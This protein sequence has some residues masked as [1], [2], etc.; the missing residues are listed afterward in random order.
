MKKQKVG[1]KKE[2]RKE[3]KSQWETLAGNPSRVY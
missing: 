3:K 2:K 1:R